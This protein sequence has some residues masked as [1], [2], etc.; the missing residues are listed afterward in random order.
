M[1]NDI[2]LYFVFTSLQFAVLFY[3]SVL[4][5]TALFCC[6]SVTIIFHTKIR[7]LRCFEVRASSVLSAWIG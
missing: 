5:I 7:W 4:P 3:E 2:I 6:E 1:G